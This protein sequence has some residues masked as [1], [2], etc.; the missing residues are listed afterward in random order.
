MPFRS[1]SEESNIQKN[2]YF[3]CRNKEIFY[4]KGMR[5]IPHPLQFLL[6]CQKNGLFT[7]FFLFNYQG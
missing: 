2:L 5:I 6:K 4:R 1:N 7:F 3:W